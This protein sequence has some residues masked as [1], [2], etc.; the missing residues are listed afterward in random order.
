L[1]FDWR[2]YRYSCTYCNSRRRDLENGHVGGKHD[3][4]PLLNPEARA[5]PENSPEGEQPS[6]LDPTLA[7]DP[8]LLYFS[9]DGQVVP[10]FAGADVPGERRANESVELY[11]LTHSALVDAR[12]ELLNQLRD[13]VRVGKALFEAWK[14]GDPKS[15]IA[16]DATVAQIKHRMLDSAEYSAAAK[17]MLRGMREKCHPW[18]DSIL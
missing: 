5:Y 13:L 14:G 9:D 6:L 8:L 11:H 4:F 2:N 3:H 18:I 12:I 10:R 1:A 17:D 15:Q 7:S 16:F